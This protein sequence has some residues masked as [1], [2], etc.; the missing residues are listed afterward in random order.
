MVENIMLGFIFAIL[1]KPVKLFSLKFF[2]N[3]KKVE[4]IIA[5]L[6]Q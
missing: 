4:H 2:L 3:L 1:G 5:E 6:C